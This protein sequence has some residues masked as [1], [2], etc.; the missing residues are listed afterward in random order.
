MGNVLPVVQRLKEEFS[1]LRG[2]ILVLV[3]S[4]VMMGFASAIPSTYYSLYVLELGGSA[5]VIGLIGFLSLIPLAL[6]QFPGGY[7]ADKNGRRELIVTMTFGVALTFVLYAIA[8]TWHFILIGAILQN[9]CLVYQPALVAIQHDS[10]RPEKRGMGFSTMALINNVVAVLSPIIAGVLFLHYGLVLGVRVGYAVV[11]ISY[12]AAAIVRIKL[13]ETLKGDTEKMSFREAIQAYPKAVRESISA[14]RGVPRSMLYL[15]F[16]LAIDN[17]AFSMIGPY[18]LLYATKVLQIEEF[19]WALLMTW[20]SIV[21]MCS[22]LPSGK[23]VDKIGRKKPLLMSWLVYI[24]AMWL[25]IYGDLQRLF[26]YFL[27]AGISGA[28]YDPAVSALQADLVPREKRGKVTGCMRF[29]N[30]LLSGGAQLVGGFLYE[31]VSPQLPLFF[32][33]ASVIPCTLIILLFIKEP[34]KREI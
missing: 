13:R 21:V 7:L 17:F 29:F 2:N 11:V 20:L 8:P 23:I 15:F 30:V 24:P 22:L 12:L 34:E 14:W 4:W 1:F 16:T 3:I 25:F 31:Y 18:M 5:F 32:A 19:K 9:L 26:V 27:I 28:L 6:V 33:L 10:L